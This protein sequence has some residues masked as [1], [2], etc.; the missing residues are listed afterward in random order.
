M[1]PPPDLDANEW[2]NA[3]TRADSAPFVEAVESAAAEL[4]MAPEAVPEPV[5]PRPETTGRHSLTPAQ[6]A[7]AVDLTDRDAFAR[8]VAH[9]RA[10]GKAEA[11]ADNVLEVRAA[12]EDCLEVFRQMLVIFEL[13]F[14]LGQLHD[15]PQTEAWLRRR[16]KPA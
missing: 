11:L 12:Q 10:Q 2:E 7:T 16:F 8:G 6:F 1:K 4:P 13:T 3:P 5:T 9:G 15:W 14:P